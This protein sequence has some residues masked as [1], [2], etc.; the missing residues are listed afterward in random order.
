MSLAVVAPSPFMHTACLTC[1][2][3]LRAYPD[4]FAVLQEG[5]ALNAGRYLTQVP[6]LLLPDGVQDS[7]ILCSSVHSLLSC[8]LQ[9]THHP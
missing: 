9:R 4:V 6:F 8:I 2:S 3:R 5:L 1:W 7:L